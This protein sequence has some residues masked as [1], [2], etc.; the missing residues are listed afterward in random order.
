MPEVFL[1]SSYAVAL[2]STTDQH[3]QR[4]VE[5]S[6]TLESGGFRLIATRAVIIEIGNALAKARYRKASTALIASMDGDPTIEIVPLSESLYKRAFDLY[7]QMADKE[8][9][10]TDCISFTVMKD[11]GLTDALTADE[12]FKQAGFRALLLLEA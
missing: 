5:I 3:H 7:R 11:R 2:S 9:G 10:L 1:D 8:W 4:A 12:H 6:E